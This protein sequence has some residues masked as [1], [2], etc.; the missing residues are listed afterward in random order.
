MPS[1][2]VKEKSSFIY[3]ATLID[4]TGA[5]VGPALL[6]TLTLTLFDKVTGTILNSRTAQNILNVNNVAVYDALQTDQTN[7]GPVSYNLKWQ[8]QPADNA[9]ITDARDVETH[10]AL[11]EAGWAGG[12]KALKFDVELLVKNLQKVA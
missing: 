9:I 6:S 1:F 7:D 3:Y 11:F 4:E 2:S 5:V 10:L 12:Q 8:V